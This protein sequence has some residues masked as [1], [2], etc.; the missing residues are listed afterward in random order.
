M[1]RLGTLL[2]C[3][4]SWDSGRYHQVIRGQ[5][6]LGVVCTINQMALPLHGLFGSKQGRDHTKKAE[7]CMFMFSRLKAA[8]ARAGLDLTKIPLTMDAWFVSHPLRERRLH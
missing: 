3:P 5:D 6:V 7:G 1:D 2:R 8:L 4:W